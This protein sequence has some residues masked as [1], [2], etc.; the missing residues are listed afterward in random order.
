M[1]RQFGSC[2][3]LLSLDFA[4]MTEFNPGIPAN[5][6][7]DVD[8]GF[9][10]PVVSSVHPDPLNPSRCWSGGP[11]VLGAAGATGAAEAQRAWCGGQEWAEGCSAA[12]TGVA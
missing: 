10:D 3:V 4:P 5:V 6:A 11:W 9:W 7:G 2:P 1:L 12:A 8:L